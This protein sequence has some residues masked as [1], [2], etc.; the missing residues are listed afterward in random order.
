MSKSGLDPQLP[1]RREHLSVVGW[2][3]YSLKDKAR[4]P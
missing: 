1:G 3:D 4:R 2:T